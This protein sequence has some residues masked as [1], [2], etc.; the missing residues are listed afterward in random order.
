MGIYD[1]LL[2]LQTIK[3]NKPLFMPQHTFCMPFQSLS[4]TA[5]C[6]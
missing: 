6:A 4:S 3:A 1:I 2:D 5:P